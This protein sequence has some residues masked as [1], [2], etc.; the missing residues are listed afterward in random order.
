[1]NEQP[2]RVNGSDEL[3][4][5]ENNETSFTIGQKVNLE[6]SKGVAT[7]YEIVNILDSRKA[8]DA[9]GLNYEI[10]NPVRILILDKGMAW[11][12]AAYHPELNVIFADNHTPPEVMHHEIIHSLEMTKTIPDDLKDFYAKVLEVLPDT[13]NLHPN[14]RKNIHEFVADAYSKEG[15]IETLRS[16]GLYEEFERLTKYIFNY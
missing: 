11:N 8:V 15:L 16:K 7:E 6:N 4:Y 13:S 14:F 10:K 1:M 9:L 3:S 5:S 2:P 12:L